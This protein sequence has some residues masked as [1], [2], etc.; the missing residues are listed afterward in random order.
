MSSLW[1]R[2]RLLDMCFFH[3]V[4]NGQYQCCYFLENMPLKV[5]RTYPRGKLKYIFHTPLVKTNLGRQAPLRRIV[6]EYHSFITVLPDLDVFHDK[7]RIF[8]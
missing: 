4:V 2:R 3:K 7:L 6:D 8:I 5:P 1:E